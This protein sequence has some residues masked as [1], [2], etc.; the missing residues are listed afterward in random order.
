MTSTGQAFA[1][2]PDYSAAHEVFP[3]PSSDAQR[4]LDGLTIQ[5]T[6][7]GGGNVS[8]ALAKNGTTV[9]QTVTVGPGQTVYFIEKTS[10]DDAPNQDIGTRDDYL[11]AV[12][13]HG[14][15]LQ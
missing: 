11:V 7:L 10:M 3:T 2:S 1:S 4:V 15:I 5:K 14:D 8:V 9:N 13:A 12:D 6:D